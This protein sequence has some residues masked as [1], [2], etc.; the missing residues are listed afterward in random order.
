[1]Y[2]GTVEVKILFEYSNAFFL[3]ISQN[4]ALC[5]VTFSSNVGGEWQRHAWDTS[6]DVPPMIIQTE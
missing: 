5:P 1:M 6:S 3:F 2:S 4:A